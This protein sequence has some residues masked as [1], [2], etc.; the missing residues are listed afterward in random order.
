MNLYEVDKIKDR[1]DE[2][3][4]YETLEH[5]R[6]D[7]RVCSMFRDLL[8][9]NGALHLC[10]PNAEHPRWQRERLDTSERGGHVRHGYT[11]QSYRQLLEPVGFRIDRFEGI[12]GPVLVF[13]QENLQAPIR[14]WFGEAGAA[15][16]AT[17]AIPFVRFDCTRPKIPFS[18]YV[19]AVPADARPQ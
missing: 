1:F 2:I 5:I 11:E 9:P 10:C 18:V 6:D 13:L 19:R 16:I 7:R 14:R 8:K 4:C 12:G 3:V 15:V 17:I